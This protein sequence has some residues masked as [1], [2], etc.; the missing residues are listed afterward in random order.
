MDQLMHGA[1]PWMPPDD[2]VTAV[3]AGEHWD[4]VAVPQQAG[5]A[6]LSLLDADSTPPGPVLWDTRAEPR[7]YFLV[8]VGSAGELASAGTRLLSMG[9]FVAIPG[10]TSIGPPGPHWLVPPDPD[11]P[12]HLVD[13]TQLHQALRRA[14]GAF[15]AEYRA[16]Q[17]APRNILITGAQRLGQACVLCGKVTDQP[18]PAGH[19]YT[20][21]G[22][23]PLGWAVVACP[24]HASE[25][26]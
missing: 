4:A 19:V 6:A 24:D 3:A 26:S 8:P 20:P 11:R 1:P 18:T 25:E 5:L 22:Q 16:P 12:G 17:A 2:T 15:W 13:A 7:L 21:T 10:A 14:A 23:A 9:S